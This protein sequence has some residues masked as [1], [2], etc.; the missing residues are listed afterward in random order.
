MN[1]LLRQFQRYT[2]LRALIYFITGLLAL[3]YPQQFT[4]WVIY[5]IAGY[6]AFFGILNLL[7][8]F[9]HKQQSQQMGFE[10]YFGLLFVIAALAVLVLAKPLLT[11]TTILLGVMILINGV[12]RIS[13][14]FRFK[15]MNQP[16]LPW[17][18][19]GGILVII[20]LI[21]MFNA[22]TS[23]MTLVGSVLLFMG[24]SEMIGYFQ[25]RKLK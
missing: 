7:S 13:Q 16:F 18:I 24:L 1:R 12:M 14:S 15:Q 8:G 10:F 2:F 11:L 21:L 3:V 20:G 22:I 17:I 6:L 4:K 25:L 5:L 9:R 19:Y 23:I